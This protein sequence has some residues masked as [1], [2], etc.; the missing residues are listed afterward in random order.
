MTLRVA[1]VISTPRGVGGAERV[2][3]ALAARGRSE[4]WSQLVLNPFSQGPHPVIGTLLGTVEYRHRNGS[5][6]RDLPGLRRWLKAELERFRPDLVHVHLFH[7]LV[8]TS[9]IPARGGV[10]VVTHH[11]GDIFHVHG[12]RRDEFLDRHLGRRYSSIIAVSDAVRTFLVSGYRYPDEK[13]VTIRNGWVGTPLPWVGGGDRPNVVCIANFRIEKGHAVLLRAFV[14]VVGERPAH[15]TLVGTGPLMRELQALALSLGIDSHVSFV[16]AVDDVWT[17]LSK[18]DVFAFPSLSEPLGIAVMEAMA[19]GVPVIASGVGGI[20][21]LV[22]HDVTGILVPPGDELSLAR[23]LE[24]LLGDPVARAQMGE[25]GRQAAEGM[26]MEATM[27]RYVDHYRR[28]LE[29][30]HGT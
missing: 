15:L 1:H 25:Q 17:V 23:G 26:K 30:P 7:A 11:H 24:R 21:E 9:T 2:L 12:R 18:A 29:A 20:P 10:R 19:A 22:S 28:L 13:V 6:L 3:A 5:R 16:G 4:G 14:R 8:L 27:D